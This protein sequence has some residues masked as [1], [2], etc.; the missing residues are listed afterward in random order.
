MLF[1]AMKTGP[2]DIRTDE[3]LASLEPGER[4]ATL[5]LAGD[6]RLPGIEAAAAA[7]SALP[8]TRP[9]VAVD[10]GGL[11]AF[12]TAGALATLRYL[13]G[14]GTDPRAATPVNFTPRHRRILD[15]V[16]AQLGGVTGVVK[17]R[18]H[19][20]LTALG[21]ETAALA[22]LIVGYVQF[23]GYTAAGFA[24]ALAHPRRLRPKELAAQFLRVGIT[25]IPVVSLVTFLIGVVF[26]YLLG[27][28]AEKYGASIF[29]VDGVAIGMAREFSPILVAVIIAG[30]SGAAFTAQLG[31]MRLT[32]ETDA[33]RVLGLS[34]MDV[35]ILPRVFAIVVALPLLVF[36][37][38]VMGNLG[39]MLM[40]DRTLGIVPAT[41]VDRLQEALN[42]RHVVA[43]LVKAPVFALFIAI[44]G[45]RMG[46]TVSN[47]TRSIGINTTATV[48]Q[49]IVSVILL[50]ALFAVIFQQLGI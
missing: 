3:R 11:A 22:G 50:D 44:I 33:I 46:M 27:L 7:L 39:A 12:D 47:D 18:R 8:K 35:L 38:D 20:F 16:A 13:Q 49:S 40:A 41:Y 28:Q 2:G 19:G 26:A 9:V 6:W 15:V 30:R 17:P 42:L 34:P 10:G 25:A 21:R 5:R 32:E 23:L 45:I 48:V 37:G 14:I 1:A 36:V 43:G 4:G 31:T 29:V 24:T